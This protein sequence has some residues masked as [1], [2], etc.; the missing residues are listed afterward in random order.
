[1]PRKGS[2]VRIPAVIPKKATSFDVA[3]FISASATEALDVT[4]RAAA[5][6]NC[7]AIV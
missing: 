4:F 7:K 1:M 5:N 6:D 2:R 3:F